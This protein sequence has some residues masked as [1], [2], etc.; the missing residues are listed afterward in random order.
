MFENPLLFLIR[1][2]DLAPLFLAALPFFSSPA[3]TS[4]GRGNVHL[5]SPSVGNMM[6]IEHTKKNNGI[7]TQA[8]FKQLQCH[9]LPCLQT[10]ET[11]GFNSV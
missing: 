9:S 6:G 11:R 8:L 2:C 1:L 3:T 7:K 5:S 4:L 10:I